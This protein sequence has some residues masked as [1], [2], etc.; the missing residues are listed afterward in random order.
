MTIKHLVLSGGAMN[1]I[2]L[3]GALYQAMDEKIFTR[4]NISSVYGTSAGGIALFVWLLGFNKDEIFSYIINK[5]W[6]KTLNLKPNILANIFN[7]KGVVNIDF[8]YSIVTSLLKG[9]SLDV[10]IKFKDFFKFTN[11]ELNIIATEADTL[12][13]VC[14]N[15]I[16]DP[17][18]PVIEALY[19]S[20]SIPIIM[21][22]KYYKGKYIVDGFL[23]HN[24]PIIPCLESGVN[25]DEILGIRIVRKI[26]NVITEEASILSYIYIL[27]K[28]IVEKI[29]VT[30]YK[31]I[32]NEIIIYV[33]DKEKLE[34]V[35]KS[36]ETR[37]KLIENGVKCIKTYLDNRVKECI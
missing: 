37:E 30:N 1:V 32:T 15:H 34:N 23:S 13:T 12:N 8:M 19:M 33:D 14:L 16:N 2:D 25:S 7:K 27:M 26:N 17:D 24:Y 28:N 29:N 18:L 35:L 4:E 21:Q 22:P 11:I 36:K 5:P 9:K 3:I 6:Y 10:N 20:A 31:K